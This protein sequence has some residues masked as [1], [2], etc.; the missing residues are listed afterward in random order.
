MCV[1]IFGLAVGKRQKYIS[2]TQPI[3]SFPGLRSDYD[4]L[5]A[6]L[7]LM[8]LA[9]AVLPHGQAAP[10]MFRFLMAA[11]S[12]LEVHDQPLVALIW[13]QSRM[14][15]LAGFR[16]EFA[17]C[18]VSGLQVQEAKVWVSPQ[19]GGYVVATEANRYSDR[20]IVQ[21][22][23]LYGASRIA[24]LEKPP[25]NLKFAGPTFVMLVDFWESMSESR[26]PANRQLIDQMSA[27]RNSAE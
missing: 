18:V 6:G 17:R 19:A 2:Q 11:L 8:E 1:C 7:A 4:R 15:Q 10:E 12:Y 13:A 9:A 20:K 5:T 24:D 16:P 21:A 27:F 25:V 3:S 26:L 23:V 22:E 14:M